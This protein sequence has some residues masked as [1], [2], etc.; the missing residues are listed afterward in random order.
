MINISTQIVFSF[1]VEDP[2]YPYQGGFHYTLEELKATTEE[3][4]L[5]R[6]SSFYENWLADLKLR[7]Q[8]Q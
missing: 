1:F 2:V 4:L 7:E 8:E 6:A 5:A 3:E